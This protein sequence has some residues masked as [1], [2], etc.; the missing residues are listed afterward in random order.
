MGTL[1]WHFNKNTIPKK[2]HLYTAGGGCGSQGELAQGPTVRTTA[3]RLL[4]KNY[5]APFIFKKFGFRYSK[6]APEA[7]HCLPESQLKKQVF[8]TWSEGGSMC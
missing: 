5:E 7:T 3:W 8:K 2:R 4:F 6:R 1:I